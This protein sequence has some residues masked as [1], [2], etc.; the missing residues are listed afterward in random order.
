MAEPMD[1]ARRAALRER[2]VWI[3]GNDL[4]LRPQMLVAASDVVELLDQIDAAQAQPQPAHEH[5]GDVFRA[6][7]CCGAPH[8]KAD[9]HIEGCH[10]TDPASRDD[11]PVW[12][13]GMQHG[14]CA[15]EGCEIDLAGTKHCGVDGE[16]WPCGW[17]PRAVARG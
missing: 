17:A 13:G 14:V 3:V 5:L 11:D 12:V 15:V 1:A 2:A 10:A 8:C 9:P 4:N 7:V 6:G 16:P